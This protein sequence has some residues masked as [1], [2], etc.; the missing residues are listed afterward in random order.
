MQLSVLRCTDAV[1]DV[2]TD[3]ICAMN[4]AGS[5]NSEFQA[6]EMDDSVAQSD[7]TVTFTNHTGLVSLIIYYNNY[8]LR[9]C[10]CCCSCNCTDHQCWQ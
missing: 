6:C 4:L 5:S 1:A 9:C 10:C 2:A 7:A 3:D 8:C